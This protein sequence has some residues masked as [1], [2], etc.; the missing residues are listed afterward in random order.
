MK[1][2]RA[3]FSIVV[4]IAILCIGWQV[5]PAFYANYQL[6]EAMDDTA[7]EAAVSIHQPELEVRETMLRRAHSAGVPITSEQLQIQRLNDEVYI[8]GEY[9]V[10]VALPLYPFDLR[11][12]PA[13][14]SKKR[15]M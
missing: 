4:V 1:T 2:L 6:E 8:W 7:R 5:L 11:F 3:I 14:K 12:R 10:H 9:T 15:A 13:S